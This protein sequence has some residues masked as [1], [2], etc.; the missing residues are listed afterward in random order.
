MKKFE[1]EQQKL[2]AKKLK[3]AKKMQNSNT[4]WDGY[5]TALQLMAS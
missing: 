3:R 2:I 5:F 4:I 1:K